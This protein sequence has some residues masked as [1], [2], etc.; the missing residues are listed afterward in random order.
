M[1][2]E[3]VSTASLGEKYIME[4]MRMRAVRRGTNL[5]T[6]SCFIV[7]ETVALLPTI[8]IVSLKNVFMPV[9]LMDPRTNGMWLYTL[10]AVYDALNSFVLRLTILPY[11]A[12][13]VSTLRR[14]EKNII[15]LLLLLRTELMPDSMLRLRLK[16]FTPS[17]GMLALI[18]DTSTS[19]CAYILRISPF[20]KSFRS[21]L[22][23]ASALI[24]PEYAKSLILGSTCDSLSSRIE[25]MTLA[26]MCGLSVSSLSTFPCVFRYESPCIMWR[27]SMLTNDLFFSL[28]FRLMFEGM[29]A[30]SLP[31]LPLK[32][33][34]TSFRSTLPFTVGS[35]SAL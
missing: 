5:S 25:N 1:R 4:S 28:K 21:N 13:M 29:L 8:A 26:S 30:L 35:V 32:L 15:L 34:Q 19:A 20:C 27:V 23:F 7:S 17:D 22:A 6:V 9:N 2:K 31:S 16:K 12:I 3:S 11:L 33:I 18:L 24:F 10:S 14:V